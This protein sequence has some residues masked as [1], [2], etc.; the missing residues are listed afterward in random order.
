MY[1]NI[2]MACI[3]NLLTHLC[4]S[5]LH[6]YTFYCRKKSAYHLYYHKYSQSSFTFS[7]DSSHR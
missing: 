3:Y 5:K 2:Y 7:L 1:M 4:A 6:K